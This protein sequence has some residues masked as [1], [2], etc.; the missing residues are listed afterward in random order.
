M[1]NHEREIENLYQKLAEMEKRQVAFASEINDLRF[2]IQTLREQLQQEKQ[3]ISIP[4]PEVKPSPVFQESIPTPLQVQRPVPEKITPTPEKK[5]EIQ[6]PPVF[7]KPQK[8]PGG[9][10]E[11]YIGQNLIPVIGIIITV[12]GVGIGAKYAIDHQLISPLTRIIIGYLIGGGLFFFA[13]RLKQKYEDF[14]AVLLSGSMA[15]FYF[16]TLA[17]YSMYHLIPLEITFPLMVVFTGYT[18]YSSIRYDKQIIAH[19]GLIGA[20]AVPFL[21]NNNSGRIGI[22]FSYMTI[23]NIG[24]LTV[25]FFRNWRILFYSTF[26]LTWFIFIGWLISQYNEAIHF[27]LALAFLSVFFF[28]FYAIDIIF[29]RFKENSFDGAVIIINAVIFY[30]AGAFLLYDT[31][32]GTKNIAWF[33]L[34]NALI[35]GAI[36]GLIYLLQIKEKKLQFL[37]NLLALVFFTIFL[38]I[39][40]DGIWLML[41]WLL[42]AVL[43]FWIGRTKR[44]LFLE[45]AAHPILALSFFCL[46]IGWG[47]D[48]FGWTPASFRP[49]LNEHFLKSLLFLGGLIFIRFCSKRV[50]ASQ[51]HMM[52]THFSK[53]MVYVLTLVVLYFSFQLEISHYWNMKYQQSVAYALHQDYFKQQGNPVLQ[54]LGKISNILYAL[55]FLSVF[56]FF[57]RRT[58][59]TEEFNVLFCIS[60]MLAILSFLTVGLYHLNF[61]HLQYLWAE[62]GSIFYH[63][64][65]LIGVRYLSFAILAFALFQMMRFVKIKTPGKAMQI[66]MEYVFH[67]VIVWCASAELVNWM[68]SINSDQAY[69]LTLSIFAGLYSLFLIVLG[70]WKKKK[71]LRIGAFSLFGITLLKLFLYDISQLDTIFKTVIFI[72]LGILLLIIAFLYNKYKGVMFGDED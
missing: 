11:R 51:N 13:Y 5:P 17:A 72:S 55:V 16:V 4:A 64:S 26:F 65:G 22:F 50:P 60:C 56:A 53:N 12:I 19:I 57:K 69:K 14:S 28:I 37:T 25:S 30:A 49:L 67:T 23:I 38:P 43:L 62:E 54:S 47:Q 15:I 7:T 33:T 48:Y 61:L 44:N 63:G 29:K 36:S 34:L 10:L 46:L 27:K 2:R 66:S 6:T 31:V 20:Y 45:I 3:S 39:Q 70:I 59:T 1:S 41:S 42:E 68:H 32:D 9:G 71:Y 35:H 21:V 52:W 58:K 8:N 40:F 18:V 24:I